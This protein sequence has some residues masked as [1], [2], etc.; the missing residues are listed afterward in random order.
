[1]IS[2]KALQE[3]KEIYKKKFGEDLDDKT[4]MEQAT[5]LITLVDAIYRPI[6]KEWLDEYKNKQDG[7]E[8]SGVTT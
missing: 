1:M 7:V 6:K 5:K 8:Q 2:D 4:A 3:Y